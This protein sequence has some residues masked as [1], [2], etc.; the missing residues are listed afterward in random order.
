MSNGVI[1]TD[2][3]S[4]STRS[5]AIVNYEAGTFDPFGW[6]DPAYANNVAVGF[7]LERA[8]KV[9]RGHYDA[10][11]RTIAAR[12]ASMGKVFVDLDDKDV[13]KIGTGGA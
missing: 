11:K 12:A 2:D 6:F 10:I 3:K 13:P 9:T 4:D 8:A 1:Y 5:G 7:G